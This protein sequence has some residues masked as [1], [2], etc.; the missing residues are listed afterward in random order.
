MKL[1]EDGITAVQTLPKNEEVFGERGDPN[2]FYSDHAPVKFTGPLDQE[3]EKKFKGLTYN[4]FNGSYCGY[5]YSNF[6]SQEKQAYIS[7]KSFSV[8]S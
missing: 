7:A 8:R 2:L 5:L 6:I 1:N 4:V 3:G